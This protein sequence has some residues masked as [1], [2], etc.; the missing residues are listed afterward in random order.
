MAAATPNGRFPCH[1]CS[2]TF[3]RESDIPRH[4]LI[5]TGEKPFACDTCGKRFRQE[6]TVKTHMNTHTGLKPFKCN[7]CPSVFSDGSACSRHIKEKHLMQGAYE[8]PD[9]ECSHRKPI[10]RK[11]QFR[12]H[13]ERVH[14]DK[15]NG[16]NI[17]DFFV[18]TRESPPPT[19]RMR[20]KATRSAGSEIHSPSP[21]SS[22]SPSPPNLRLSYTPPLAP[23]LPRKIV[24]FASSQYL[25]VPAA[26][27]P[28]NGPTRGYN[29]RDRTSYEPFG[30][31]NSRAAIS[32]PGGLPTDSNLAVSRRG[33]TSSTSTSS[34]GSSTSDSSL[35]P[36]PSPSPSPLPF[37]HS[38]PRVTGSADASD[39]DCSAF[40][41]AL[42]MRLPP[43]PQ[44]QGLPLDQEFEVLRE[45]KEEED[46]QPLMPMEAAF[47]DE[48]V[49]EK[50]FLN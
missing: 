49:D 28:L 21:E 23:V 26:T 11:S 6:S 12:K 36:S 33:S 9:K 19:R 10:K 27:R 29:E 2:S 24:A 40:Y 30:I 8:C 3:S 50:S 22:R 5:H 34:S 4:M 13:L 16:D 38:A 35:F 32:F 37:G 46:M 17:E 41:D 14:G 42:R 25:P 15:Y 20:T 44:F 31:F 45:V 7:Y 1:L 18:G 39:V 47:D 43:V 48:M